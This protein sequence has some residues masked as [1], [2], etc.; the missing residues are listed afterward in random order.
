M[1]YVIQDFD[2]DKYLTPSGQ[3]SQKKED[4]RRFLTRAEATKHCDELDPGGCYISFIVIP[5]EED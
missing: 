4:A 5:V 1:K 3:W 2:D